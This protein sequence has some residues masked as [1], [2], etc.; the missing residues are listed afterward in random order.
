MRAPFTGICAPFIRLLPSLR[1]LYS[2]TA[3]RKPRARP[4][5][6]G[7]KHGVKAEKIVQSLP[8]K[9]RLRISSCARLGC[10]QRLP[11]VQ[12]SVHESCA[13]P[14]CSCGA[15]R[16]PGRAPLTV[17]ARTVLIFK[18]GTTTLPRMSVLS[19]LLDRSRI[20]A[21]RR[22]AT[23]TEC[24]GPCCL[25]RIGGGGRA[26]SPH[27]VTLLSSRSNHGAIWLIYGDG[28]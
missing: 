1:Y 26:S 3:F 13:P 2:P 5:S 14:S 8:R 20:D 22:V 19:C 21:P 16:Y 10:T 15:R 6:V 28:L 23:Y 25:G 24:Q 12:T 9:L 4:I 18:P 7:M 11:T 17:P 27:V